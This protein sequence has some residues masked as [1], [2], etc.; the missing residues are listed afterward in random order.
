[1]EEKKQTSIIVL[2]DFT[3]HGN[4][5]VRHA[6]TLAMVFG[7]SLHIVT[8]FSFNRH[9]P[10][11]RVANDAFKQIVDDF[12]EKVKITISDESFQPH[13]L[14]HFAERINAIMY[15]IGVSSKR[16]ETFF[17]RKKA[18]KFIAPSRLP[19]MTVGKESP[20]DEKWQNVLLPIDIHRQEKEKALWAGYFNR[21]GGATVHVLYNQYKDDFLKEKVTANLDFVD[22]LYSNLEINSVQKNIVPK[23]EDLD[24]YALRHANEF[25][26]SVLVTMTTSYK[27]LID[28][29]FGTHE[30][31]LI[32]NSYQVPVL[33]LNERDDLYVLCT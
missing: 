1:M 11:S 13:L 22:K 14:H 18:L 12:S 5:A 24:H 26:A 6:A 25:N 28:I 27:T 31:Y 9:F 8:R 3:A 29:L 21:F 17:N 32:A 20:R 15:V 33:C 23:K 19:V 7:A 10:A 2:T 4:S 16:D 30:K